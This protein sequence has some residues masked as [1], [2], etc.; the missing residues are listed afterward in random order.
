MVQIYIDPTVRSLRDLRS[1]IIGKNYDSLSIRDR[2][3]TQANSIFDGQRQ[4]NFAVTFYL[5][6]WCT[7]FIGTAPEQIM[8]SSLSLDQAQQTIA[9]GHGYN[10]WS[11]VQALQDVML[12]VAF[13]QSVD[14]VLQGR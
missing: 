7:D 6:S 4:G 12:D 14:A 10:D 11:D 1:D 8:S 3:A 5:S 2:L 13:E 9:R